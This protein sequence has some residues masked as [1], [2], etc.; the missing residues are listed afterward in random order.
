MVE[1]KKDYYIGISIA[2]L[3]IIL[4]IIFLYR[5]RWFFPVIGVAVTIGWFQI[6]Y[7]VFTTQK[8]HREYEGRFLDFVRNFTSALKSGMPV[9]KAIAHAADNDYG[10]LS[11]HVR[12]LANQVEWSIP[13]HRALVIFSKAT[14]SDVI[15][16]SVSTVI[17]A[18]QSGGNIEDVLES[19][20]VSLIEI[21]K[22]KET[23]RASIHN[24]VL[25]SYI[26]FFVFLIVMVIIQNLLLPYIANL[27][28]PGEGGFG[29]AAIE[30]IEGMQISATVSFDSFPEFI[31]SL[32]GW[33]VSLQGVFLMLALIQGLFAGLIIGKLSEGEVSAGFKHSLVLMSIAFFIMTLMQG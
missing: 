24:Q 5:T 21:K 1:F 14:K 6:W 28:S 8:E 10:P 18:E 20:T 4:D 16:R 26:I 13:L 9:S 30:A 3:I 33:F 2:I 17:E 23:R 12:K 11:K 19:I 25:Q 31:D 7:D 27:G 15:K 32:G 29:G 22:I